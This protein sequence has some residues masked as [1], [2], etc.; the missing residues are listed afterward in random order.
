MFNNFNM[1]LEKKVLYGFLALLGLIAASLIFSLRVQNTS[2]E[3]LRESV[4]VVDIEILEKE[5]DEE[6]LTSQDDAFAETPEIVKI[7]VEEENSIMDLEEADII[8]FEGDLSL[9][10]LKRE[11][12]DDQFKAILEEEILNLDSELNL[13]V[14]SFE[15]GDTASL[16]AYQ[17]PL[18]LQ[19]VDDSAA[20]EKYYVEKGDQCFVINYGC[21]PGWDSFSDEIGCGCFKRLASASTP[22]PESLIGKMVENP[23]G[24]NLNPSAEAPLN[25]WQAFYFSRENPDV[26]IK[27]EVLD[28]LSVNYA[29]N[30]LAIE[31]KEFA[32][33]WVS[34]RA[35]LVDTDLTLSIAQGWSNTRVI[36]DGK[37][38]YQGDNSTEIPYTF[39][40]GKHLIEVEYLNNWHTVDF[41]M[42]LNDPV[43][44]ITSDAVFKE[45]QSLELE[46]YETALISVYES[47]NFDATIPFKIDTVN[48]NIILFLSSYNSV[49]WQ[50]VNQAPI[51]L[52]AVI[53]ASYEPGSRVINMP[54]TVPGVYVSDYLDFPF[55][56][57][58]TCYEDMPGSLYC[59][60]NGLIDIDKTMLAL[61]GT[62]P[63][64]FAGTYAGSNLTLPETEITE[65]LRTEIENQYQTIKSAE[66]RKEESKN[67]FE[68][69]F[70]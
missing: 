57:E 25:K 50:L 48:E 66:S 32:G 14:E 6:I 46:A 44:K 67:S 1:N 37:L 52:K 27:S 64:Y 34:E 10:P 30:E 62:V 65:A 7:L 54:E 58:P 3:P 24:P 5:S 63:K 8:N 9:S 70:Y 69:L 29:P 17:K 53:V 2:S 4:E 35:F 15:F 43:T 55:S 42:A 36:I 47:E 60:N 56:L 49:E 16:P 23:W 21:D 40:A 39:T 51:N 41:I 68:S 26:F 19:E 18:P 20:R 31:P 38:V 11:N 22:K 33:Y 59:E 28:R 12:V 45:I 13:F 61:S